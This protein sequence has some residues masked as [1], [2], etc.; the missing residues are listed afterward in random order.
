MEQTKEGN[1]LVKSLEVFIC[2][3]IYNI[4]LIHGLSARRKKGGSNGIGHKVVMKF[5]GKLII[6]L[7]HM[8]IM[9]AYFSSF[10]LSF[11]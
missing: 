3:Q 11:G 8:V 5:V 10:F 7:Q 9:D 1:L 6:G 4:L 2:H